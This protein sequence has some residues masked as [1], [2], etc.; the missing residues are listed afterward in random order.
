LFTAE[1]QRRRGNRAI[2]PSGDRVIGKATNGLAALAEAFCLHSPSF[3]AA[4]SDSG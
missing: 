3:A 2:A 1:A 4:N